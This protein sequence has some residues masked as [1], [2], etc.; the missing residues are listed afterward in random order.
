MSERV[1]VTGGNGFIGS[2]VVEELVKTKRP[3]RCMV[4]KGSPLSY[5]QKFIDQN[6]VEIVYGD[7]RKKAELEKAIRGCDVIYHFVAIAGKQN[8]PKKD[9]YDV[10]YMGTVNLLELAKKYKIKKFVYCSSVGVMGNIKKL[11]ADES[12]PYNPTNDYEE[13]KMRAEQET[14]RYTKEFG[15]DTV[16]VRPAIVYGP[17][18]ISNMSR[19]FQ[20]I[21]DGKFFVIGSGKNLWHMTFI[22]DLAKGFIQAEK[23]SK[24]PGEVYI[25]AGNQP[26]TMNEMTLTAA[27]ILGVKPPKR[28]PLALATVAGWCLY[29]LKKLTG[30]KVPLEPS[31][32]KFLT[33][34]RAYSIAK[35][36]H[37][38]Q[39]SPQTSLKDGLNETL[40]WYKSNQVIK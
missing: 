5:I 13:T 28:I 36:R 32:V 33:N 34:H 8:V 4:Q 26:V 35:A 19:M 30:M 11:P 29:V 37:D 17:R 10:N 18:N 27:K 31:G 3:I 1:L 40:S 25:L 9:Y 23:N 16:I 12:Y 20:A 22:K 38:L 24:K 7:V 15:L 39:Y 6:K 2:F 14:I 21:K